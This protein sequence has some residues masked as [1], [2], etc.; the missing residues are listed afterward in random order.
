[1]RDRTSFQTSQ[2]RL[3]VQREASGPAARPEKAWLLKTG[4][5]RR[6]NQG[7]VLQSTQHKTKVIKSS[8]RN[9]LK[10]FQLRHKQ[11]GGV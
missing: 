8:A 5:L 11:H 4:A 10:Y 6:K 7:L 1:M 9:T 2:D 3:F